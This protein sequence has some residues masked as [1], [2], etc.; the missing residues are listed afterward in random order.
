M[1]PLIR[2]ARLISLS[3]GVIRCRNPVLAGL[4]KKARLFLGKPEPAI[5]RAPVWLLAFIA[6]GFAPFGRSE[7]RASRSPRR[8]RL[9]IPCFPAS[10][11][12]SSFRCGSLPNQSQCFDLERKNG[13]ADTELSRLSA[14]AAWSKPILTTPHMSP[15][16]RIEIHFPC[17][18]NSGGGLPPAQQ[19]FG[20]ASFFGE[21][22]P[23]RAE[24]AQP[25]AA[26]RRFRRIFPLSS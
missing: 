2:R 5:R 12:A 10:G 13:G 7:G 23:R 22:A 20:I 18:A 26:C 16:K 1:G 8:H 17:Q 14:A 25:I 11:K 6:L 3:L 4:L 9:H 21:S 19:C 15:E 24:P